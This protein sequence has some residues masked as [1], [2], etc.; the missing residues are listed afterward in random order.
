MFLG[1][2]F[3]FL[4]T[5]TMQEAHMK[6]TFRNYSPEPFHTA[7]YIKVREFLTRINADKI[8][9]P[10]FLWGA[11][12]W[13]V[14]HQNRDQ[15]KLDKIGLWE[16]NGDI[17]AL[18]TYECRFGE[19]FIFVDES[20]A[21]LKPELVAYAKENLHDN[22][23]LQILIPEDDYEFARTAKAQGFRPTQ[24]TDR[25][26]VLDIDKLQSYKLPEGFSFVSM[27]DGWNWE[28][29]NRVMRRGFAGEENPIWNDDIERTRKLMLSSPMIIPE[30]IVAVTNADGSYVAHCGIW[31][32]PGEPYCYI[33]PVVTDP[34]YQKMGLGKAV[35]LESVRRAGELGA[36]QAW[37]GS[38]KQFY[39]NIG[40]YPVQTSA[41][42]E[43]V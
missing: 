1:K 18:A 19:G 32:K 14:T 37:V 24:S 9:T 41:Y 22:G 6:T 12:E 30:L 11:W 17:V 21:H 15:T 31:Y 42:W 36:V 26:A 10:R 40:F 29:Y 3:C 38:D 4:S 28:E 34:D 25:N 20:Y 7:D 43:L 33:E 39:Y 23:K 8:R 16:D 2:V 5:D 13:A 35:V 27:A